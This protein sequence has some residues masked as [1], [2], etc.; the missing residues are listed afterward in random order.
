M[1]SSGALV[2]L[3]VMFALDHR[4]SAVLAR[5]RISKRTVSLVA[6]FPHRYAIAERARH[7]EAE[8]S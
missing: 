5:C 2:P 4:A 1:L 6:E 7:A 8:I 3:T